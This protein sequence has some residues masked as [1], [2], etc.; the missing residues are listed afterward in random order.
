MYIRNDRCVSLDT[1][2]P[3][4]VC[5]DPNIK[6]A[7]KA[8]PHPLELRIIK[9]QLYASFNQGHVPSLHD[10]CMTLCFILYILPYAL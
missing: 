7:K 1:S 8:Y 6:R 10:A 3:P 2:Q 5:C 4:P 9:P